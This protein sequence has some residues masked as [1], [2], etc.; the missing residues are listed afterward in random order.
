MDWY[1]TAAKLDAGVGKDAGSVRGP[2][3]TGVAAWT[4][5]GA[6]GVLG[7]TAMCQ[8]GVWV[9]GGATTGGPNTVGTCCWA[10]SGSSRST[11]LNGSSSGA[12]TYESNVVGISSATSSARRGAGPSPHSEAR[13]VGSESFSPRTTRRAAY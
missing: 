1:E 13:P 10:A 12:G 2:T 5:P 9:G 7:S 4:G 3:V 6:K 11:T 8:P